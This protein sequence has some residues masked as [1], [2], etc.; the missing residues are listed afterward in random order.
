ML[1]LAQQ[2]DT[3]DVDAYVCVRAF[4]RAYFR[5][6]VHEQT[7]GSAFKLWR[8]FIIMFLTCIIPVQMI[9]TD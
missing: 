6:F 1:R 5:H 9:Q 3:D 7:D 2:R 4:A 8:F